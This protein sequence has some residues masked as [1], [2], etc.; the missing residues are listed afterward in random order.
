MLHD[1][2]VK[3]MCRQFGTT[4]QVLD[5]SLCNGTNMETMSLEVIQ[6][7]ID[8]FCQLKEVN[9][10]DTDLS[11]E[12]LAYVCNN[13]SKNIVKVG[14]SG[15]ENLR[16][17]HISA[18]SNR[19]KKLTSLDLSEFDGSSKLSLTNLI[20]SLKLNLEELDINCRYFD[21]SKF[22]ELQSM[23]RLKLL[24]LRT[25]DF[26]SED[27]LVLQGLLPNLKIESFGRLTIAT[28]R[29]FSVMKESKLKLEGR[30][31]EINATQMQ[32]STHTYNS[33]RRASDSD[34]SYDQGYSLGFAQGL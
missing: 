2:L 18:L 14:L 3:T 7:M 30:F 11:K 28:S 10:R 8:S 34:T 25:H 23:S 27:I 12:S 22:L 16:D 4:L 24:I 5:L 19:C 20:E 32:L 29:D 26:D 21:S 6:L 9:F 13:L 17:K 33:A 31:W 15:Q 1:D